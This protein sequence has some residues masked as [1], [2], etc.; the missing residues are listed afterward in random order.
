MQNQ[1]IFLKKVIRFGPLATEWT[2]HSASSYRMK[3]LNLLCQTE[4]PARE[5]KSFI[6]K[7]T[8]LNTKY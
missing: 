3:M 2:K 1:S 4:I 6:L 7:A 8:Q 5:I